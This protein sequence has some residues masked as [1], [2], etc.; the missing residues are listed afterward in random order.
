MAQLRL[1][2]TPGLWPELGLLSSYL[3]W[4]IVSANVTLQVHGGDDLGI[5]LWLHQPF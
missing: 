2:L 1:E 4:A 5:T 3:M